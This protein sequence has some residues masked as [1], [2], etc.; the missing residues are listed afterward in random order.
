[1]SGPF[2]VTR[3]YAGKGSY[4]E[5]TTYGLSASLLELPLTAERHQCGSSPFRP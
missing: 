2:E 4:V 1:M 5:A 3:R